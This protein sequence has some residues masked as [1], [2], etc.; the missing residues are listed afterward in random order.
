ME[1]SSTQQLDRFSSP[2]SIASYS[3]DVSNPLSY[4]DWYN[5]HNGIIPGQE[6]RQYNEYLVNWYQT[7]ALKPSQTSN[8]IRLNYLNLLS[9]LQLFI[10]NQQ[11]EEFYNKIN[12]E[13]EKEL[14]L[15]IPYY[16]RKLRDI[17]LYYCQLRDKIKKTKLEYNLVGSSTGITQKLLGDILTTY[18]QKPNSTITIPAS[19]WRT[20]PQLSA[21]RDTITLQLEGYYDFQEYLGKSPSVPVS[22]YIDITDETTTEYFASIGLALSSDNWIYSA[23]NIDLSASTTPGIIGID[24]SVLQNYLSQKYLGEDKY[25]ST[26]FSLSTNTEY[27]TLSVN[28]GNNFFYWPTGT[29]YSNVSNRKYYNSTPLS[30]SGVSKHATAGKTL[31][32]AD[33]IFLK[34]ARGLE[35]AWYY[36]K[37]LDINNTTALTANLP[38]NS[39]TAFKFPY[40]GYG[41]SAEDLNWTGFSLSSMPTY[42]FLTPDLKV[43]VQSTYWATDISKF[44]YITPL[45]LVNTN[46]IF[47]QATPSTSYDL[48]D[49]ITIWKT[50]PKYT[51]YSYSS[52]VQK[53]WLY[54]MKTTDIPIAGFNNPSVIVWPYQR[55]D[56]TVAFPSTLPANIN[57]VC[58]PINLTNIPLNNATAGSNITTGDII[59]KI[60]NYK[61]GASRAIEA[62]W[63]SGNTFSVDGNGTTTPFLSGINQPGLNCYFQSG[64]K[65]RFVW[66]GTSTNVNT[67][68]QTFN[69]EPDCT[70]ITT[71]SATYKDYSLC[72]CRAVLFTPFGQ[73]GNNFTDNNNLADFI[74]LDTQSPA[75]FDLNTWRGSDGKDYTTSVDFT[76]YKTTNKIGWGS[77][78]WSN[79]N[80]TFNP[81]KVYIYSRANILDADNTTTNLPN[82]V[83]R[84]NYNTNNNVWVK[85]IKQTN[86]AWVSLNTVSD[87]I[88]RPGDLLRFERPGYTSFSQYYKYSTATTILTNINNIWASSDYI[89]I[90]NP[91]LISY[92]YQTTNDSIGNSNPSQFPTIPLT[93]IGN[94]KLSWTITGPN[95]LSLV[96]SNVPTFTFTPS[97]SGVYSITL[98]GIKI[99]PGTY[100]TTTR[101]S[102]VTSNAGTVGTTLAWPVTTTVYTPDTSAIEVF[103][104]IPSITAL[105]PYTLTPLLTTYLTPTPGYVIN[106]PLSGWNYNTNNP[107]NTVANTNPGAYPYWA[108]AYTNKDSNTNYKGIESWGEPQRIIDEH[109][110]VLQPNISNIVLS[111]GE[112]FEYERKSNLPINWIQPITL[113]NFVSSSTWCQLSVNTNA[114]AALANT[115]YNI[116]NTLVTIPLTT[117]STM[118]LNNFVDNKPVEV[119][120]NAITPFVWNIT[121]VPQLSTSVYTAPN[122]IPTLTPNTPWKNLTNRFYPTFTILPYLG[123]L[124]SVS[125]IGGF[126]SP[127]YLGVTYYLDRGYSTNV[128]LSSSQLSATFEDPFIHV[129]GRGLTQ[130]NQNTPF[131]I[132]DENNTWLKEPVTSGP[133]AGNIRKDIAKKYQK[134]IPYQSAYETKIDNQIGLIT[135]SSRQSPWGGTNDAE[136]T[137]YNNYPVNFAGEV[138]VDAWSNAQI[139]KTSDL[140]LDN[141]T[142][143][144]FGNQYGLY[145]PLTNVLP[146]N[147]NS[148]PGS[149]WTRKNSQIVY[150]ASTALTGTFVSYLSTWFYNELVGNGVVKLEVFFDTLY[151]QTTGAIFLERLEYNYK[152]NTLFTAN[153]IH[154]IADYS[155]HISLAMPITPSIKR[156]FDAINYSLN[157]NTDPYT[158]FNTLYTNYGKAG[159]TWFFP[160]EKQLIISVCGL[161]AGAL[162]PQL[163]RLDIN[164]R[165]FSNIFPTIPSDISTISNSLTSLNLTN[166]DTPVLSYDSLSKQYTMSMFC[167]NNSNNKF[168][169]ELTISGTDT[170]A[171]ISI[172]VYYPEG[173]NLYL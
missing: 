97:I 70:F 132:V 32:S 95:N 111:G 129:G 65:T 55:I 75:D 107:D 44:S 84:Y 148:V 18:T 50:P 163:Y 41:L 108:K 172:N 125:Q 140:Q 74:A 173:L 164:T 85:A 16:A 76:W 141:W 121:A 28:T 123:A 80:F 117:P 42:N 142:T 34:T 135:P 64:V 45:Q 58:Q 122:I 169:V 36:L 91:I 63:L 46:L 54:A 145:K 166:F 71:T 14:L 116:K 1:I 120:Y 118:S 15:A 82:L 102:T 68:F 60:P 131:E 12:I 106:T 77:G 154:S 4:Y 137:D 7:A 5:S 79:S 49:K 112:Y 105:S 43:A 53:A 134:F 17:A 40:P 29:Y 139:L 103:T 33:T 160:Q 143:D 3:T 159:E 19:V 150:P 115:L 78:N 88:V 130:Q 167:Y 165:T 11:L 27:Y 144:I 10:P 67:V 25:S 151:V 52:D 66:N 99:T 119:Y 93:D 38:G 96:Y 162:T 146:V 13:D 126:F 51:D 128:I 156:E 168:I 47:Q 9:Q 23:G 152:D 35:G 83:V 110:I 170:P 113:N 30:S 92:P 138:N 94:Y 127:N 90:N 31:E 101:V 155:N 87:M 2:Q 20:V 39:K 98:T 89:T 100:T 171:L 48:A 24:P 6:Y 157:T 114:N 57:N 72:T 37:T 149:I 124:S 26:S 62:A 133:A 21:I 69:H 8:Q 158:Y 86:G 73:P 81:N 61:F 59:Y 104:N 109:N 136:W 56:T 161:S 147:R 153:T 22:S